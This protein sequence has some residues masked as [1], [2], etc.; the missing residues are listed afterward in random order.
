MRN[1]SH[2]TVISR[3][4]EYIDDWRKAQ[5]M[6][7]I[8]VVDEIVKA[9]DSIGG[10]ASTGIHFEKS[11]DEWNRQKNNAD[12][13]WRWLDDKSKD[14][15]LLPVNFLPSIL[16]AMPKDLRFAFLAE[17]LAPIGIRL[18]LAEASDDDE[19]NLDHVIDLH[20]E[21]VNAVQAISLAQK[22]PTEANLLNA[23]LASQKVTLRFAR[24]RKILGGLKDR[25]AKA[26]GAIGKAFH[27]KEKVTV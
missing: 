4:A 21:T 19:L 5:G 27:R 24:T 26:K 18:S 2:K 23:E 17:M 1:D 8:T 20:L 12:R 9:H 3:L 15:N 6:S 13:V 25:M 14:R 11:T 16:A 7:Q 10:P 22:E